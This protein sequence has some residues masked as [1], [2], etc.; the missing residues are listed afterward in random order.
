MIVRKSS[1]KKNNRTGNSVLCFLT[2]DSFNK[3]EYPN[4]ITRV[5]ELQSKVENHIAA[6]SK[7][8]SLGGVAIR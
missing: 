8:L 3:E 4:R 2:R 7:T 6:L 5:R 1:N